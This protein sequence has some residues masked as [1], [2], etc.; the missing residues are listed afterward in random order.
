M[1]PVHGPMAIRPPVGD[2]VAPTA[3][4]AFRGLGLARAPVTDAP[5]RLA[6]AVVPAAPR[7]VPPT[8]A[9]V[10]PGA[11]PLGLDGVVILVEAGLVR[12]AATT[13]RGRPVGD[14]GDAGD[15]PHDGVPRP[16]APPVGPNAT[17]AASPR[18]V[19][20]TTND[21]VDAEDV[22]T[23]GPFRGDVGLLPGP[24]PQD[25]TTLVFSSVIH[26][27]CFE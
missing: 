9:T 3:T 11:T 27:L 21:E 15:A 22:K 26:Y 13:S 20:R 7:P 25:G 23:D 19:R 5:T 6:T 8:A 24:F 10:L 1:G 14:V 16:R 18:P 17:G 12:V 4:D 2:V